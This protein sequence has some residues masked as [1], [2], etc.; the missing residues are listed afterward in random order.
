MQRAPY[1][2]VLRRYF[3]VNPGCSYRDKNSFGDFF[4]ILVILCVL[5]FPKTMLRFDDSLGELK[6]LSIVIFM[7]VIHS[8]QGKDTKQI[9]QRE[10]EPGAKPGGS[11]A[12]AS[13]GPFL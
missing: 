4:I 1:F 8:L 3:A 7:A 9:Q 12:Q 11:Q 2:L 13:K 6:E 10:K 5:E